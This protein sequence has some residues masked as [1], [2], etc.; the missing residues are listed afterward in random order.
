MSHNYHWHLTGQTTENWA[1]SNFFSKEECEKIIEIGNN[2]QQQSA[3]VV[4]NPLTQETVVEPDIRKGTIAW[5][6][7]G[8]ETDWIFQKCTDLV[9]WANNNYFN[10]DLDYIQ[11]LQFTVYNESNNDYYDRHIDMAARAPIMRKLSF[12]VQL[13]DPDSYE[14]GDL[15]LHYEPKPTKMERTQGK[16]FFFPSYSL[17]EVTPVTKGTRYSLVGWVVGP[18]FK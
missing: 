12:S 1:W 6:P 3:V 8:N 15:I 17:H 16:G 4:D 5:I 9:L 13:S 2:L 18:K 11:N 10:F 14:G 7:S